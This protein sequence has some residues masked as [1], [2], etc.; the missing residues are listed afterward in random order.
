RRLAEAEA[1]FQQF[2]DQ[3]AWLGR[4][5]AS[6][7]TLASLH[8]GDYFRYLPQAGFLPLGQGSF[9]GFTVNAFFSEQPHRDPEF[10]DGAIVRSAF[11]QALR[12]EPI[13]LSTDELAWI[14]QPWQNSKAIADGAAIQPYVVFT[15]GH[16]PHL[17][18]ARFDLARWDDSNYVD[19]PGAT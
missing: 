4:S 14:Y 17:A 11:D 6:A 18:V 8:A 19:C 15:T 10:V 5:G 7:S 9:R 2:Q 3:I 1:V 12:Y 13:D 16:M